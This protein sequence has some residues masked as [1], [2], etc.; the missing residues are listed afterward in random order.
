MRAMGVRCA[1]L[2]A[3]S[4]AAAASTGR[5]DVCV[6]DDEGQPAPAVAVTVT[7]TATRRSMR[8]LTDDGGKARFLAVSGGEVV[9]RIDKEGFQILEKNAAILV[10]ETEHLEATLVP[11]RRVLTEAEMTPEQRDAKRAAELYNAGVKQFEAGDYAA[12]TAGVDEALALDPKLSEALLLKARLLS[13]AGGHAGA[14][15]RYIRAIELNP[16]WNKYLPNLIGELQLS[17]RNDEAAIY[18]ARLEGRAAETPQELYDLALVK[19]NAGDDATGLALIEKILASAPA[20]ADAY[21]QR[22]LI[23]LRAGATIGTLEDMRRYIELAPAGR[24]AEDARG[25]VAALAK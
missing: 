25:F 3:A 19:I 12:A 8:L 4:L 11:L 1:V 7:E 24:H 5:L 23:R 21:F 2:A 17:G 9:V 22:G 6:Q 14:A 20:H 13:K 18:I 16:E 10:G 15:D